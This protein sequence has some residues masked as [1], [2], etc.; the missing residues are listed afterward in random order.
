MEANELTTL[1]DDIY[2]AWKRGDTMTLRDLI[3]SIPPGFAACIVNPH[4][5]DPA[6][7]IG[8]IRDVQ[9]LTLSYQETETVGGRFFTA[10]REL[11]KDTPIDGCPVPETGKGPQGYS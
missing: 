3:H 6:I 10:K 9:E 11:E 8:S 7:V 5:T 2:K 1:A 4:F